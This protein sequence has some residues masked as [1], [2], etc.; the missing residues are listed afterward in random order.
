MLR[1]LKSFLDCFDES[2]LF[3][4][5]FFVSALESNLKIKVPI[6]LN[7]FIIGPQIYLLSVGCLVTKLIG[8]TTLIGSTSF[9][10]LFLIPTNLMKDISY[11]PVLFKY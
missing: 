3:S 11:N 8:R 1:R 9:L 4:D 10:Y 5:F 6:L 7:R 2:N